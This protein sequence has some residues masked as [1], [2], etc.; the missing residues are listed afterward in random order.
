MKPSLIS[1]LLLYR[2]RYAV[3]YILF[4][5]FLAVIMFVDINRAPNGISGSEMASVVASNS[6]NITA[7]QPLDVVNLPYHLLQKASIESLG[8]SPLAIKLPSLLLIFLASGILAATLFHWFRKG[9]A[10][11]ALLFAVTSIPF[12]TFGRTGTP[13]VLY[14]LLLLTVLLGAVMMNTKGVISIFWKFILVSAGLLLLYMPLGIYAVLTV[15]IAGIF[16]PHVRHQIRRTQPWQLAALSVYALV[17]VAPIIVASI[18]D[19]KVLEILLGIDGLASRLSPAGI[20]ATLITIIKSL[21]GFH[22]TTVGEMVTPF[23]SLPFALFVAFGLVRTIVDRHAAR[24]YLLHIW[25]TVSA[26]ILLIDSSQIALLFV[27]C[28]MLMA[29]GL[30]TFLREW[31]RLFPRNPYAR[32][33]A[34]IPLSLIVAGIVTISANRYF[35]S[36]Y[37]LDTSSAYHPELLAVRSVL[38]PHVETQLVVPEGQV[39]FYDIL[40]AKNSQLSVTSPKDTTGKTAESIVLANTQMHLESIPNQIVTSH[41]SNDAVLLRTYGSVE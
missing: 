15:S 18:S 32:I 31:Y 21:F 16:H 9:I 19:P 4:A 6:I 36:Y 10:I 3:G 17:L 8:L 27:P 24:S 29:I 34:L 25:L 22:Q 20:S 37:Y 2:Y 35:L 13:D 7:L 23:F 30:E 28:I 12:I 1:E 40:R 39:S 26:L 5:F 41:L 33:T 38:K 11:I 14:I